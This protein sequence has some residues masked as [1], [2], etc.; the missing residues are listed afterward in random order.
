MSESKRHS[1]R[2]RELWETMVL[3]STLPY[4]DR[5]NTRAQFDLALKKLVEELEACREEGIRLAADLTAAEMAVEGKRVWEPA[6]S[7]TCKKITGLFEQFEA[8]G[9]KVTALFSGYSVKCERFSLGTC[10]RSADDGKLCRICQFFTDLGWESFE[11]TSG[12]LRSWRP[13]KPLDEA[14][15]NPATTPSAS[16]GDDPG[17]ARR[18]AR[19]AS[20]AEEGSGTDSDSPRG[21]SFQ[22]PVPKGDA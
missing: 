22:E 9:E 8:Q 1:K 3:T 10:D 17:A 2:L 11:V 21:V 5:E 4:N 16:L 20:D 13:V 6:Q 18:L 7:P 15:L 14:V 12:G 19:P